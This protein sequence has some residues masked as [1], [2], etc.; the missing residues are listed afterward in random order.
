MILN[1]WPGS[2]QKAV[3]GAPEVPGISSTGARAYAAVVVRSGNYESR[4]RV[5]MN[6]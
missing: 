1:H 3:L 5:R 4:N 2:A 6:P